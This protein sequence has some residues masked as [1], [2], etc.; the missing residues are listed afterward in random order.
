MDGRFCLTA[1]GASRRTA[2]AVPPAL[3]CD[4]RGE[5]CGGDQQSLAQCAPTSPYPR[6]AARRGSY[7]GEALIFLSSR[8]EAA[9]ESDPQWLRMQ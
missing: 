1:R 7:G 2:T 5:N 6:K 4:L 3:G 8:D 9:L